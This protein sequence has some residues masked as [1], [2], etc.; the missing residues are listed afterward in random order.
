MVTRESLTSLAHRRTV[1]APRAWIPS[2]SSAEV[3]GG[4]RTGEASGGHGE[5]V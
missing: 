2:A 1:G 3:A 5:P 4:L